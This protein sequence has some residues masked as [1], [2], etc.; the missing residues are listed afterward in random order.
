MS[1][2]YYWPH[3]Y[4]YDYYLSFDDFCD[5]LRLKKSVCLW[6]NEKTNEIGKRC[7]IISIII[8]RAA[9]NMKETRV[10]ET[11]MKETHV[12]ETLMKETHVNETWMKKTREWKTWMKKK[13]VF[14]PCGLLLV[15]YSL[16]FTPCGLLLLVVYSI[17]LTPCICQYNHTSV[18]RSHEKP[19]GARP[20]KRSPSS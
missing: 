7:I 6:K 13:H 4:Y 8:M 9:N 20:K 11:W 3:Y 15:V 12:N 19:H 16:W 14:T 17:F 2:Y 1:G 5:D 10:N 18:K